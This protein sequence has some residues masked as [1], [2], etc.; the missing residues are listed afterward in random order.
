MLSLSVTL[1][2][3]VAGSYSSAEPE[4]SPPTTSTLPFGSNVDVWPERGTLRLP[5]GTQRGVTCPRAI[6]FKINVAT[7]AD[8][9]EAKEWRAIFLVCFMAMTPFRHRRCRSASTP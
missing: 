3:L 8:R 7:I 1:Q 9:I 4:D 2:V 6:V 5:V